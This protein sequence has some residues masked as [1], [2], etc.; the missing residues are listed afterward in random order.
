MLQHTLPILNEAEGAAAHRSVDKTLALL[1]QLSLDEFGEFIISLP[2]DDYPALTAMLP[3]MVSENIQKTWTGASGMEL[4][5]QSLTF[6]RQ[7]ENN[8]ARYCGKPLRN[9]TIMDFG[10]GYGR[11]LRLMYYFSDP[12]RIWGV[13]A[14]QGSLDTCTE[15]R[16]LGNFVKSENVPT[17]LAVGETQF[18]VAYALSV[19]THL[20][21][22]AAD[23]CLAAVR[24]HMKEGGLFIAT[25][26]PVEYWRFH[27]Q[28]RGTMVADQMI[29]KHAQSGFAYVPHNGPEGETYGDAS[30]AFNFFKKPGWKVLG[31]DWS[32]QDMYQVSV[33]L[34]AA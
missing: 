18:D 21:P 30:V 1:R 19:F 29:N 31:H 10:C 12:D 22:T 5:R 16:M 34:Q 24:R 20:A 17:S 27:D 15:A 25:V 23:A 9:S 6:A 7:V 8:Y 32:R 3:A 4:L 11:I 2:R 33:V 28:N 13:D 14:W 26:R